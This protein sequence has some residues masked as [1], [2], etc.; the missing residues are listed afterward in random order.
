MFYVINQSKEPNFKFQEFIELCC[1]AF[2]ILRKNHIHLLSIVEL[3]NLLIYL[4][5]FIKSK[6]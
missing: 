5:N 3:V 6:N 1:Q 4:Q 2:Q